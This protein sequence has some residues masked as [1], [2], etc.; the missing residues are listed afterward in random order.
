MDGKIK[1]VLNQKS[2][3]IVLRWLIILILFLLLIYNP[4]E[5]VILNW[6]SFF[7]VFSL[8]IFTNLI[9][10]FLPSKLFLQ[11]GFSY[12]IFLTDIILISLSIY[13]SQGFD[14]DIYLAYFLVIF[15]ASVRQEIKGSIVVGLI[16]G[17]LYFAL[18][19]RSGR[20]INFVNTG[21][22]LRIPFLFVVALFSCYFS[23]QVRIEKERMRN[24][25][26]Q[27]E[28]LLYLGESISGIVHQIKSPI[29]SVV[30]DAQLLL[31][32][33]RIDMIKER[34]KR[35]NLKLMDCA[36]LIDK[37]LSFVRAQ[38]VD[39]SE[40]DI[41]SLLDNTLELN[42][43]QFRIDNIDI[44]RRFGKYL[45]KINADPVL[46]QQVFVNIIRNAHEAIL[47]TGRG[48]E[49]TVETELSDNLVRIKFTDNGPGIAEENLGKI[50]EPFFTT[51]DISQGTGL[52][53]NIAKTIIEKHQGKIYALSQK[54]KGATVVIELLLNS[55]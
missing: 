49:L 35:I 4:G 51:K 12:T 40:T 11:E 20:V 55:S 18:L 54:G 8:Y 28:R 47:S 21:L 31:R 9:F 34:V 24:R 36:G 15:M 37:L 6:N 39:K 30:A 7:L 16:S 38:R 52:G 10:S 46:L 33:D 5:R 26:I 43:D 2:T 3:V 17:F 22:L 48:G 29:S 53:L 27:V 32:D 50:F 14:S 45:P 41:N 42:G 19:L 13:F 23:E 25:I 44:V 1:F